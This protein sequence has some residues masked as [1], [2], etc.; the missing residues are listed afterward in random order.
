[1]PVGD[2][3]YRSKA[4]KGERASKFKG[5]VKV[6]TCS[7]VFFPDC[8]PSDQNVSRKKVNHMKRIMKREGC[9][10]LNPRHVIVGDIDAAAL[11][12]A[13]GHCMPPLD[14]IP[15]ASEP[16]M[17]HLPQGVFIRC[18]QG[19]SRVRALEEMRDVDRWWV[20][21]LYVGE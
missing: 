4:L 15:G 3:E 19:R 14:K 5:Y 11:A 17:L 10:R 7:L 20:I 12:A 1:M 8:T 9:D 21:E 16:F 2:L 6:P 13:L 18:A